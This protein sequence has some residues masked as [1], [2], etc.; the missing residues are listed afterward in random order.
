MAIEPE[1]LDASDFDGDIDNAIKALKDIKKK[2]K[3]KKVSLDFEM[4]PVPYEDSET[5]R[6]WVIVR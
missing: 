1:H 5:A 3:G 2:H 4:T 6:F